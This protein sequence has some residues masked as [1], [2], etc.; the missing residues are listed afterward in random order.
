MPFGFNNYDLW[1]LEGSFGFNT[2]SSDIWGISS[3]GLANRW[4]HVAAIFNNGDAKLS[5]LFI[6]GVEPALTQRRFSTGSGTVTTNAHISGWPRDGNYIFGGRIDE[7]M[8][9]NRALT[10]SEIAATFN[11]GSLGM[12]SAVAPTGDAMSVARP[13]SVQMP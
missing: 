12:C 8:I 9:H 11:A 1:F 10:S 13:L 4:V 2:A 5:R 3:Q 6:D 7:V